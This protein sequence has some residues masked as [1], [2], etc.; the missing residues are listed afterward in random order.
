MIKFTDEAKGI[1]ED[2][3]ELASE[4]KQDFH[5]QDPMAPSN[6]KYRHVNGQFFP[7]LTIEDFFNYICI[8]RP[9]KYKGKKF[10]CF[11]DLMMH[12]ENETKVSETEMDPPFKTH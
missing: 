10:D 9:I 6:W 4:I 3:A 7:G 1:L 11:R 5:Y 8:H 12:A 2:N